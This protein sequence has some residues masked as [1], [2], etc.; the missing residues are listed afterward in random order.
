MF[1]PQLE[2]F[3]K[4][5]TGDDFSLLILIVKKDLKLNINRIEFSP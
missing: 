5:F 2:Y 1:V 4:L 3:I